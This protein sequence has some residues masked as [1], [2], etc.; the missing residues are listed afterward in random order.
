MDGLTFLDAMKEMYAS[1]SNGFIPPSVV[2]CTT[3]ED[4]EYRSRAFQ[5]GVMDYIIKP[6][7]PDE[8]YLRLKRV[9]EFRNMEYKIFNLEKESLKDAL[10]GLWNRK[11]LEKELERVAEMSNR[12]HMDFSV[13][14]M[15]LDFF[16]KYNEAYGE[17]AGDDVLRNTGKAVLKNIR[18]ADF[19][20]RFGGEEFLLI[21]PYTDEQGAYT[22][23]W[24]ILKDLMDLEIEH[25][26]NPPFNT[27]TFT[28]GVAL[29]QNSEDILTV[30]RKA[31]EALY[32]GKKYN[33]KVVTFTEL[34]QFE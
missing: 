33:R 15:D 6:Y 21:L 25:S 26:H 10:T 13:I 9:M 3:G 28:A 17:E 24:R 5:R 4:K 32:Y 11:G 19:A 12:Y 23:G 29:K 18:K 2:I 34:I 8:L 7:S 20:G 30:I 16:S 22:L 31:D 27:I 14:M 1:S